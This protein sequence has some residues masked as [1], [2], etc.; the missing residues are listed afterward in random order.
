MRMLAANFTRQPWD[1][2]FCMHLAANVCSRC[3]VPARFIYQCELVDYDCFPG[4]VP[5]LSGI[6]VLPGIPKL[7]DHLF[8]NALE[9]VTDEKKA[10]FYHWLDS[11]FNNYAWTLLM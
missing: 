11:R 7:F 8:E 6:Q 2:V 4:A 10:N 3:A 5:C 9:G 1:L